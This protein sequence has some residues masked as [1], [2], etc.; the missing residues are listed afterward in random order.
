ME[1]VLCWWEKSLLQPQLEVSIFTQTMWGLS[2]TTNI[3]HNQRIGKNNVRGVKHS[4][5]RD[6]VAKPVSSRNIES[7]LHSTKTKRGP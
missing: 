4:Q 3:N 2:P 5:D 6:T 7:V 1:T